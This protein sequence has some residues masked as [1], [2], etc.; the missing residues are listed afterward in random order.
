MQ[1]LRHQP[2]YLYRFIADY[3]ESVN[4]VKKHAQV[5]AKLVGEMLE[6]AELE[7]FLL[8]Q[9]VSH[10]VAN[11]A[12][13]I[14]QATFRGH[15][16][17]K[18]QQEEQDLEHVQK[19]LKNLGVD[20]QSANEAARKIQATYRGHRLR[21]MDQEELDVTHVEELMKSL[22]LDVHSANEAASKIQVN[23]PV[24]HNFSL[25]AS[26]EAKD[27]LQSDWKLCPANGFPSDGAALL[28]RIIHDVDM[29]LRGSKVGP[30][31]R[32]RTICAL[33]TGT[34]MSNAQGLLKTLGLDEHTANEAATKIQASSSF[35]SRVSHGS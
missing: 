26:R 7:S 23:G 11:R 5:A 32:K 2:L 14:I 35:S 12:S 33:Q 10:D 18:M 29:A 24:I 19:F 20:E 1:V 30:R 4:T 28:P 6:N 13:V 15:R 22:G 27:G 16:A 9:G 17:R 21:Q 25:T 31:L 8:K 34:N 3:L